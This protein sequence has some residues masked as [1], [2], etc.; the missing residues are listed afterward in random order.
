[1]GNNF[2]KNSVAV[3]P[4]EIFKKLNIDPNW[5]IIDGYCA[6]LIKEGGDP[7]NVSDRIAFIEKTPRILIGGRWVS[8]PKGAGGNIEEDGE[9]IYGFY[10]PS[11]DW[12]EEQIIYN[13]LLLL[14]NKSLLETHKDLIKKH[15]DRIDKKT[16][17]DYIE[18][19]RF[20]VSGI[21]NDIKSVT[22]G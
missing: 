22:I 19:L 7:N 4:T 17:E 18:R 9:T 11:R 3:N 6:A 21:K 13:Y 10:Q 12:V 5:H 14:E 1:M 15:E 8:G 16:S 2:G 20:I